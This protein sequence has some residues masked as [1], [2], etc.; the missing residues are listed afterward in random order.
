MLRRVTHED[1][2][3]ET[4]GAEVRSNAAEVLTQ[5]LADPRALL[6]KLVVGEVV[7]ERVRPLGWADRARSRRQPP[8][9]HTPE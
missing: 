5:A 8:S 4:H 7:A 1:A 2:Y 3:S 6:R 9:P